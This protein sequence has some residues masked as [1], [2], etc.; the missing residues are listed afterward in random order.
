MGTVH[1]MQRPGAAIGAMI[2]F[3]TLL[4]ATCGAE[5]P[6]ADTSGIPSIE[7]PAEAVP[8]ELEVTCHRYPRND[9]HL[10]VAVLHA[11]KATAA[12]VLV[13]HGGPG[14]RAVAERHHWLT[15]RSPILAHHD[16]ILVDQRGSGWSEPSLDCPEVDHLTSSLHDAYRACRARLVAEGIDLSRYRVADIVADL[17]AFRRSVGIDTW[18]L[19]AISFGTLVALELLRTDGLAIASTVLDSPLPPRVAAYDEL[20]IGAGSAIDMAL[21]RCTEANFCP[22][23]LA[24]RLDNLLLHLD[25]APVT[26]TTRSGSTRPIDNVAFVHLLLDALAHPDGPS[27][28]PQAVSVATDG[29]MAEAVA[30]LEGLSTSGRTVGD[31]LSEG[32]QLSSEC[33]DVLPY[34]KVDDPVATRP[35]L[36]AI[37]GLEAEIRHLCLIWD[38]PA[39]PQ[40][41]ESDSSPESDVLVLSGH[42]DPV[43]PTA[44]ARRVAA[45]LD[46]A[47]LVESESWSHAPSLADPCAAEL[48]ARFLDGS[49]PKPGIISC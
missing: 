32:A 31:T 10:A 39:G 8:T 46:G 34:D 27:A 23:D 15:P 30:A 33:A 18:S 28:L 47:I 20:P 40:F 48:V 24:G 21:A 17:I 44:W 6:A 4:T 9:G 1:A 43:T 19:Y 41:S 37:A 14:G 5:L 16:M 26:V 36:Q 38:V 13:I 12:P 7:C 2:A 45:D 35:L 49:R 29:R 11:A 42:L 25:E 22:A 3:A